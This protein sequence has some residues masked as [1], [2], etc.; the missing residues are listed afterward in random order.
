M[1]QKKYTADKVTSLGNMLSANLGEYAYQSWFL[2]QIMVGRLFSY[3][4]GPIFRGYVKNFQGVHPGRLTWNIQIT[5]LE[6]NMIFQTS[7]IV[8]YVNLQG[9]NAN[10]F[11]WRRFL[12][13][14]SLFGS[15]WNDHFIWPHEGHMA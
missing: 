4:E 13:S 2:K 12:D 11:V 10:I 5:H 15:Y 3:W 7:M 14:K 6:R 1:I 9:S 8:F